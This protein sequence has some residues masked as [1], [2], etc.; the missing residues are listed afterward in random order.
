MPKD[1]HEMDTLSDERCPSCAKKLTDHD[2]SWAE[3]HECGYHLVYPDRVY[4]EMEDD[5]T[6]DWM[7]GYKD[8]R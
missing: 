1:E 6:V 3:C 5:D 2:H 8:E 4:G 7:I